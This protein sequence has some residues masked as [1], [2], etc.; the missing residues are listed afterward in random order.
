MDNN[1]DKNTSMH[2]TNDRKAREQIIQM[3]GEGT[4]FKEMIFDK[5]HKNGAERHI[6]TDNAI[7]IIYNVKTNRLVTKLIARPGQVKR[8]FANEKDCPKWLINKARKYQKMNYN[9]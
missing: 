8:F 3:I 9:K 1:N 7:I 6:L 5:G 2:Y 4:P